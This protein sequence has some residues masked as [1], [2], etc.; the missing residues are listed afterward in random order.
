MTQG[1]ERQVLGS[2]SQLCTIPLKLILLPEIQQSKLILRDELFPRKP[3]FGRILAYDHRRV[4]PSIHP[5]REVQ[6]VICGYL[7]R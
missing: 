7:D 6:P 4:R 1:D 5:G 3:G 2:S